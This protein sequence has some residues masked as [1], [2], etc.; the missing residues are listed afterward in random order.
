MKKILTSIL[1]G[2]ASLLGAAAEEVVEVSATNIPLLYEAKAEMP[3]PMERIAE[4][5]SAD[6]RTL[7]DEFSKHEYLEKIKPSIKRRIKEAG[8]TQSFFVTVGTHL[9]EYDFDRKAFPTGFDAGSFIPFNN[10]AVYFSNTEAVRYVEVPLEE[11]KKAS[12]ALKGSRQCT[13]V[14]T[15]ILEKCGE[16]EFNYS[17]YKITYLKAKRVSIRLKDS[18]I[19]FT[20]EIP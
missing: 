16:K 8:E 15:G 18:T 1:L 6:Y 20:K 3:T 4:A 19:E 10:Y 5:I 12:S 14:F 13:I 17:L 9:G 2:L 11:A 7:T